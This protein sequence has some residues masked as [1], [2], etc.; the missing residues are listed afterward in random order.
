MWQEGRVSPLPP[1]DSRRPCITPTIP[2]PWPGFS[3]Y[4]GGERSPHVRGRRALRDCDAGTKRSED[5]PRLLKQRLHPLRSPSERLE[6]PLMSRVGQ[7]RQLQSKSQR[8]AT[9][10]PQEG[11]LGAQPPFSPDK[12]GTL[13]HPSSDWGQVPS[14]ASPPVSCRRESPGP[15]RLPGLDPQA[16]MSSATVQMLSEC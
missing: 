13:R 3:E 5:L 2:Q 6:R 4:H 1:P 15:G 11:A 8:A 10:H 7:V 16:C 14:E 12:S 9:A